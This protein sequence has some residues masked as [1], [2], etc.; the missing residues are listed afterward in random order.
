MRTKITSCPHRKKGIAIVLV[1]GLVAVMMPVL[2]MLSRIGTS[3]SQLAMKYHENLLSETIAF[4][5]GNAGLS[6]L[7]GNLR[8]YQNLPDEICGDNKYALN[9]RPTGLGFFKQN[10]YFLLCKAA[11]K[12]HSY[13]LMAEAEQFRPEPDPPVMV[14]TR[15]YW[16]TVEPYEIELMADVLAM[17]NYRGIDLLRFE[18][19]KAFELGSTG[20]QYSDEMTAK[21]SRLPEELQTDWAEAINNLVAEKLSL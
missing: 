17:Q 15:D 16:N 5:A 18:E 6:R 9:L 4:S 13:T 19:T 14:I 20:T 12:N 2:F 8:G 21:T 11:V 3:Q 1:I 10:L 7:Q